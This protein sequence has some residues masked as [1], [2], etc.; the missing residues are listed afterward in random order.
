MKIKELDSKDY[1]VAE[2]GERRIIV[3][4]NAEEDK[5]SIVQIQPDKIHDGMVWEQDINSFLDIEKYYLENEDGELVLNREKELSKDFWESIKESVKVIYQA[6]N[7]MN[8]I[9]FVI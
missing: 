5:L 9:N 7:E 1:T 2:F 6:N 8:N 4:L 3:R